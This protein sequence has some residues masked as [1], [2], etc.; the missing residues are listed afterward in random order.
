MSKL[1]RAGLMALG[2]LYLE[3]LAQRNPKRLP[4]VRNVR[5]TENGSVLWPRE[6]LW[7]SA[8]PATDYRVWAVDP[9]AGQV[10]LHT[11]IEE[12]GALLPFLVRLRV[13]HEKITEIETVLCRR[14]G[15]GAVFAPETLV[16]TP[17]L[18]AEPVPAGRRDD[19]ETL[20]RVTDGYFTAIDTQGRPDYQPAA[21][22][23]GCDRFENGFQSTNVSIFGLPP[24]TIGEQLDKSMFKG[25]TVIDRR[26]PVVDEEHGVVLAIVRFFGSDRPPRPDEA[27]P[28]RETPIVTEM[29]KVMDGQ[30]HEVRAV[31]VT[32]PVDAP[33]GWPA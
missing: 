30:I 26:Y 8:G 14:G 9:E 2:E 11:N 17:A 15:S 21:F 7:M 12:N 6:G 28:K 19:R 1:D 20:V 32:R 24:M 13:E 22:A 4:A 18:F 16:G 10:A 5:F 27:E 33:S 23:P 25:V 29:F 31:M 3:A